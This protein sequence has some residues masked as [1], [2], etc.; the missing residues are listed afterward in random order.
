M[1]KL[2]GRQWLLR[3][4]V[5]MDGAGVNR[6]NRAPLALEQGATLFVKSLVKSSVKRCLKPLGT[7]LLGLSLWGVSAG[8]HA[9][10]VEALTT[11]ASELQSQI[12][13][14]AG[15]T[16]ASETTKLL[17]DVLV[18]TQNQVRLQESLARLNEE[19]KALPEQI[20]TLRERVEQTKANPVPLPWNTQAALEQQLISASAAILEREQAVAS[21]DTQLRQ[22]IQRRDS[23]AQLLADKREALSLAT[24]EVVDSAS[25]NAQ[26]EQQLND[27]L[28]QEYSLSIQALEL[29]A[30]VLPSRES[31]ARLQLELQSLQLSGLRAAY[32]RM[33][34]DQQAQ[35]RSSLASQVSEAKNRAKEALAQ[36][37]TSAL[38]PS[39][40]A[41]V[42]QQN[43]DLI[44]AQSQLFERIDWAQA[45]GQHLKTRLDTLT[46]VF[47]S[48]RQQL[49]YDGASMNARQRAF[50]FSARDTLDEAATQE[51]INSLRI[52]NALAQ[53][54]SEPLMSQD[55]ALDASVVDEAL[56]QDYEQLV[57]DTLKV[58]QQAIEALME[59]STYQR[60]INR[61]IENNWQGIYQQ[62]LRNPIS[63]P[64]SLGW[65]PEVFTGALYVLSYSA[66]QVG[67]SL[68][69][70]TLLTGLGVVLLALWAGVVLYLRRYYN[71]RKAGWADNIG[72]VLN[73][74]S[75]HTLLAVVLPVVITSVFPLFMLLVATTVV[76]T[77]AIG[78]ALEQ[79]LDVAALSLW[80]GWVL[81][82]YLASRNG[83]CVGHFGMEPK[84]A[85]LIRRRVSTLFSV[86]VPLILLSLW[87]WSIDSEVVRSGPFRLSMAALALAFT[88]F[89]FS[90]WRSRKN[91]NEMMGERWWSHV[92]F[93]LICLVAF[94]LALFV[95]VL[96]GYALT[97]SVFMFSLFKAIV[98][99]LVT[100]LTYKLGLRWLLITK[101]RL[102]FE[103]IKAKRAEREAARENPDDEQPLETN[104]INMQ[105]VSEQSQTL[106]RITTLVAFVSFMYLALGEYLPFIDSLDTLEIWQSVNADGDIIATITLKSILMG[107]VVLGFSM[108]AAYN[109]P[110]L[111]ELMVLSRLNL[112]PGTGYALTSLT[113]Y[114][115]IVFGVL[116]ACSYFGLEWGKLQWLVAALGV[117]LGFGLQEIVANFV[118]GL[119]I[120]FEKPM[121][122]GD[123][124]TI[125][126]LTGTVTRIQIRATTI[127]DWDRKEVIIPN[128]TF[129]TQQL[130][131]WSLS[132]S[133][134]RVVIPVGVAYG[135]D[136]VKVREL[137]LEAAH[138]N[139]KVL[140]EPP[141]ASFFL[142]FGASTLDFD[143]RLHVNAMSDRLE[144]THEINTAVDAKFKT[145]GIEIAFNQLDVHLHQ[146]P[147]K[148]EKPG[149]E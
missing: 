119:I 72:H 14:L 100:A 137:L 135:S 114:G 77:S 130:I 47:R 96:L 136:T 61:Q 110:G 109:L 37:P 53:A 89:W 86:A 127:V 99:C 125:D 82:R 85:A 5:L 122:I 88:A 28:I 87:M 80:A 68:F 74:S 139:P 19:A 113:K 83:V 133:V 63:E 148:S 116:S 93:W 32:E 91:L 81:F 11:Q 6:K 27:N 115:L 70:P 36:E 29:E 25:A 55:A 38:I 50:V 49:A 92:P 42:A 97:V 67:W 10:S 129:I 102:Q 12:E 30:L 134:T 75:Q 1:R 13:Q 34:R 94:N 18:S 140:D 108:L 118:S 66:Q 33:S 7:A 26:L 69:K 149:E 147:S 41:Q 2:I 121:R 101:R 52:E 17:N 20:A 45:Q 48:I 35:L 21:A 71:S 40:T 145:A 103:Q 146:V 142:G 60:Q 39:A 107:G 44:A 106:L 46:T 54:E 56:Q 128:K 65:L 95:M 104:Y 90:F 15:V 78:N 105:T 123:T 112:S 79:T 126:G 4:N 76:T 57:A 98:V 141:A 138:E 117:G 16:E 51:E 3:E 84:A 59:V 62:L 9:I 132:D 22:T 144:V 143:L 24:D 8:A 43:L 111:L 23:M 124:V 73:D 31:L 58:R 131:N 64:I 120:L